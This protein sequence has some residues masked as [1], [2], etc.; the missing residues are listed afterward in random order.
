M[1]ANETETILALLTARM[2]R[3]EKQNRWWIRTALLLGTVLLLVVTLGAVQN[4][5][6]ALE[7]S[8]TKNPPAANLGA[9]PELIVTQ[10]TVRTKN[11]QIV[12]DDGNVRASINIKEA[13]TAEG[14][15]MLTLF[16]KGG[17]ERAILSLFAGNPGLWLNDENGKLRANLSLAAGKPVL[18]FMDEGTDIRTEL[19]L[20]EGGDPTFHMRD[21]DGTARTELYLN[22]GGAPTF[23]MNDENGNDRVS[24]SLWGA[25]SLFCLR[26]KDWQVLFKK[27]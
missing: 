26:D 14:N 23:R 13:N 27:P 24:F 18:N 2:E 4:T 1:N 17:N 25:D 3:L 12:D 8:R 6:G 11:L 9:I 5:P 7:N 10:E 15:P 16:D 22:E 20:N 21:E 19:Y